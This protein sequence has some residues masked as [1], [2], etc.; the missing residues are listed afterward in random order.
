M[1]VVGSCD[2]A[3]EHEGPYRSFAECS[4]SGRAGYY[5]E[6]DEVITVFLPR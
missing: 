1:K 6:Y 2:D 3:C 5:R 4:T